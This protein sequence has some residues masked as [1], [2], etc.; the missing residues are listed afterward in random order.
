[1]TAT[2]YRSIVEVSGKRIIVDSSK[3]PARAL[4]LSL[5]DDINLKLIHLVRDGRGVLWSYKKRFDKNEAGGVQSQIEPKPTWQIAIQ[6]MAIN[7]FSELAASRVSDGKRIRLRYEDFVASPKL[8]LKRVGEIIDLDMKK[9][10]TEVSDGRMMS[11]GHIIA[12]NRLRMK[13]RVRLNPDMEWKKKL[14]EKDKQLF[15]SVAGWLVDRYGY[16][17]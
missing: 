15:E 13:G 14:A 9:L 8:A 1:L 5:N 3:H 17:R 10:G 4:A 11:V 6:W 16:H 2:L 7:L 12:G